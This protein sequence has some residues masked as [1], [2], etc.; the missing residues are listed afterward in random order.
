MLQPLRVCTLQPPVA[1]TL[2]PPVAC[3]LQVIKQCREPQKLAKQAITALHRD[4]PQSAAR[5]LGKARELALS[6]LD[7]DL[8][9]GRQPV[10]RG[11]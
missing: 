1:S 2:Q 8:V 6:L 7:M 3:A 5:S 4:D 9:R 11:R 10:V